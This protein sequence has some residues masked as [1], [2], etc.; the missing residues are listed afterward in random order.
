[1]K[2]DEFI[3]EVQTRGRMDSHFEA[4]KATIATLRTLAERLAGREPYD[5]AAQLPPELAKHLEHERAGAGERFSL[6][7]FFERVRERE[8]DVDLPKAVYHAG[9]VIEVLHDAVTKGEMEDVRSHFPAEYD[10]L[11]ETGS[12]GEMTT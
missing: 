8:E 2:Y 4:Q 12:Q 1:M 10:P 9:V 11:F 7:Q 5:L 6:D 3:K